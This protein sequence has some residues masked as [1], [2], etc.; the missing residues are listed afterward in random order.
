MKIPFGFPKVENNPLNGWAPLGKLYSPLIFATF[1]YEVVFKPNV[2]AVGAM[3]QGY[4][5]L[6]NPGFSGSNFSLGNKL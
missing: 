2:L 4:N 3:L 1:G 5:D 6:Y